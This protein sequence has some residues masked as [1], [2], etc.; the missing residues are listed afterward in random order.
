MMFNNPKIKRSE[1][2]CEPMNSLDVEVESNINSVLNP[3]EISKVLKC[4]C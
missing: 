2:E 4:F 1:S 3:K